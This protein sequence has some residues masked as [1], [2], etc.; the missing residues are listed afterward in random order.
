MSKSE[1]LSNI[2]LQINL[3]TNEIRSSLK[4]HE[5]HMALWEVAVMAGDGVAEGTQRGH[6]HAALDQLLDARCRSLQ[7]LKQIEALK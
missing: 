7:L 4:S 6:V 2:L 3:A 1:V 5:G